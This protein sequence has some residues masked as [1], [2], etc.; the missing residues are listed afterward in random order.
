MLKL[1]E[2]LLDKRLKI[3]MCCRNGQILFFMS[4]KAGHL[5]TRESCRIVSLVANPA[6]SKMPNFSKKAG[7]EALEKDAPTF[8]PR[9]DDQ[10]E[11]GA[12]DAQKMG[13]VGPW[14]TGKVDWSPLA[15]LTG[16]RPVVDH[17]SLTRYSEA[18]WRKHNEEVLCASSDDLHR[19]NMYD[20][21]ADLETK[22]SCCSQSDQTRACGTRQ[23]WLPCACK[24]CSMRPVLGE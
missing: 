15:G 16:T 10:V 3:M 7:G 20:F 9:E 8:L 22:Q 1:A 13:P 6:I 17:Y 23:E 18:E 11:A 24:V 5:Q 12:P 2:S 14:A 4:F 19:V 21:L